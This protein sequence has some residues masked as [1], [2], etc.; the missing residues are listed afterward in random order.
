MGKKK[1][2]KEMLPRYYQLAKEELG[3]QEVY[4]ENE[5][6]FCLIE[7]VNRLIDPVNKTINVNGRQVN[8][9]D[10][11]IYLNN[12]LLHEDKYMEYDS[13]PV[14]SIYIPSWISMMSLTI[15]VITGNEIFKIITIAIMVLYVSFLAISLSTGGYFKRRTYINNIGFY[16]VTLDIL[17]KI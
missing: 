1:I 11:K 3:I 2:E 13:Y 5:N 16:K 7:I 8:V 9:E 12:K 6:L 10:Y 4:N 17:Q 15:N 14:F